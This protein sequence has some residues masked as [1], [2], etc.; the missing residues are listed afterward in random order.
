MPQPAIPT[1]NPGEVGNPNR[2]VFVIA[3]LA[4]S[5]SVPS[6]SAQR[7]SSAEISRLEQQ[8]ETNLRNQKPDLA[9]VAYR[10]ILALDPENAGAHSNLG[11]AFYLHGDYAPAVDEFSIA[12]RNHPDQWNIVALCGISEANI[13]RNGGAIPHLDQAFRHVEEPTLLL[14]VGKRLFSLL[15]ETGELNR[16]AELVGKLQQMAPENIDV[17]YAAHQVYSLLANRSFLKMAQAAPDSARMYQLQADRLAQ[18]GNMKA[19]MV[20]YRLAIGRDSHLSGV[21]FQL[22]EALSV[23]RVAA[24]RAEAE[25]EYLKALADNPLDEKSECRLGDIELQRSDVAGAT[26][27]YRRALDLQGNDPDANDGYGRALLASGAPQEARTYLK[28]AIQLDPTNVAAYYHLSQASRK[29]GDQEEAKRQMSDF[30]AHKAERENLKRR[31][32]DMLPESFLRTDGRSFQV[33][34]EPTPK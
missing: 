21:H 32:E 26:Q 18:I 17:I 4:L 22:A 16:A 13:G 28:R 2:S 5:F 19:A 7:P 9:I 12:L 3:V 31:L 8:A 24:E 10:R 14:A 25:G 34:Q 30:L 33:S 23:S 29:A 15:Y 27:H 11:L 1:R 20:A 6:G